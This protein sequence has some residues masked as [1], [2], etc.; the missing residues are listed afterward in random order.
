M[1]ANLTFGPTELLVNDASPQSERLW[2]VS[3]Q[4]L[5]ATPDGGFVAIW[6]GREADQSGWDLEARLLDQNGEVTGEA[7]PIAS[8]TLGDQRNAVI[9]V[10]DD[11]RLIA[12]WQSSP[13]D[14]SGW[15][16]VTRQFTATGTPLTEET[17]V[18]SST[19]GIQQHP[20]IAI[21]ENQDYV[22]VWEG[23]GA[24]DSHG[25]FFQRFDSA[26]QSL[27]QETLV[28]TFTR[29]IQKSPYVTGTPDGGFAI[30]WDGLGEGDL[31]E[32]YLQRFD[33]QG[34]RLRAEI[35]VGDGLSGI[36]RFPSVA[37]SDNGQLA[38]AWENGGADGNQHGVFARVFDSSGAA[39]TDAFG[40]NQ[41]TAG[42]Q[43]Y[44]TV[45]FFGEDELIAVWSGEGSDDRR[46]VFLRQFDVTDGTPLDAETAINI[47]EG[48]PQRFPALV[49]NSN[50]HLVAWTGQ[51]TPDNRGVYSRSFTATPPVPGVSI[52]DAS[53]AEGDEGSRLVDVTVTLDAT[54]EETITVDFATAPGT[55]LAGE[56]YETTSGQLE[57][58]PGQTQQTI[59]VSV[60][61]DTIDESDET[62]LVE[63]SNVNGAILDRAS[64]VVT[65]TDDDEA[66]AITVSSSSIE[67]GDAGESSN[68]VFEVQLSQ[69]SGRSI[70][71]DFESRPGTA[72]SAVDFSD[73]SG[74][75]TFSPGTTL[76]TVSV[77]VLGDDVDELDETFEI[78]LSGSVNASIAS[79]VETGTILDDD[80]EPLLS[81]SDVII[82]EGDTGQ[83]IAE[84]AVNLSSE[85]GQTVTVDF[86]SAENSATEGTDYQS[87]SG[88]LTF[89]PGTT[90]Q[91]ISVAILNDL[92]DE[93]DESFFLN[94]SSSVNATISDGQSLVTILDNDPVPSISISDASIAE[95]Q[96]GQ[97]I[98]SFP[99]TLS[100][101]SSRQ[102]TVAFS[103]SDQSA[104][105]G[106]DYLAANGT[107]TFE[108][109]TT[110][111]VVQVS[112]LGDT[113]E[114]PDESFLVN[115]SA[116]SNSVIEDD[117]AVGTIV[118][119]DVLPEIQIAAASI[120]EGD[121]GLTQLTFP[122]I[123]TKISGS[124]VLFDYATRDGSAL[125]ES[126]F[127]ASNGTVT[128]PAG[129]TTAQISIDVLT[130]LIEE[131]DEQ[132]FIDFSNPVNAT[133]DDTTVDGTIF[134]DDGSDIV[135]SI[136]DFSIQEPDV[137]S[138][139][140][141]LTVSAS[142]LQA[143]TITVDYVT[144][145]GTALVGDDYLPAS[146]TLT[147]T[148]EMQE[149]TIEVSVLGD[150]INE[151]IEAFSV[152]L[153][154]ASL[155]TISDATGTV[156]I[157]DNDPVPVVSI[158][159]TIVNEGESTSGETQLAPE[160]REEA[161]VG[162]ESITIGDF[163]NDQN[164]DLAVANAT[165]DT[166]TVLLNDGSG[167]YESS[168]FDVSEF[169]TSIITVDVDG[170][171]DLDLVTANRDDNSISLLLNDGN[172]VFEEDSTVT[173]NGTPASVVSLDA[174]SD[175]AADLGVA[176]QDGVDAGVLLFLN[177]GNGNFAREVLDDST[178]PFLLL[179][180]ELNGDTNPD[181]IALVD[182]SPGVLVLT[183]DSSGNTFSSST[184]SLEN[185]PVSATIFD[186][187]S[188]SDSDLALIDSTFGQIFVFSNDGDGNFG[189]PEGND[190]SVSVV[191][192][193][194]SLVAADFDGDEREDLVLIDANID[195]LLVFLNLNNGEFG[196]PSQHA[197]GEAPF[198]T[199]V[200]DLNGDG[201][202]DVA[203]ANFLSNDVSI[204]LNNRQ[205]TSAAFT[206]RLS[207]PSN[208]TVSVDYFTVNGTAEDEETT[209]DFLQ[210]IGTAVFQPGMTE[211]TV[212][213]PILDDTEPEDDELFSVRLTN[214][215][216][217]DIGDDE[218]EATIRDTDS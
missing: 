127:V 162:A 135:I 152:Q 154:N 122:V 194:R 167:E 212:F 64:S 19:F 104:T 84:V 202:N 203:T 18:N 22:I 94:L 103:T 205:R 166:V 195:R 134:D 207:S 60:L 150:L 209:G 57:F 97:S 186:A 28:N 177:D 174:N 157:V 163:N 93:D 118:S 23:R 96:S 101:A 7:F 158:S 29:G 55:A 36:N 63:L 190:V 5:A 198:S 25:I 141:A 44:P 136:S 24:D 173:I 160:V 111:Q 119:D 16:I 175:G 155:G 27:G 62:F 112:I 6:N 95:G 182:N 128:I 187:D 170:D 98:L 180:G 146:G 144:V 31:G 52:A 204:L 218:G 10:A 89:A 9:D 38:V 8:T 108:P 139:V 37:V 215:F 100:S 201:E 90:E 42:S 70:S 81:I 171:L 149:L 161:G 71:V 131:P 33:A 169:P 50:Q 184:I 20:S 61:G 183:N 30:A 32:V 113:E 69:A 73:V 26:G 2:D 132:F 39:S 99:V 199:V 206:L 85:S 210:T 72:S 75:L 21:L 213:V 45:S 105:A 76:Q 91:T 4:S 181:L 34:S 65:I 80:A 3:S 102:V 179:T 86:I 40:L 172:G 142:P 15:G 14:G 56:D 126:D 11:G 79:A 165:E 53:V 151:P 1:L 49:A 114:E 159:D 123:L 87:S 12:A 117:Q 188:D 59:Q 109:G 121:S 168:S 216:N 83:T 137:G 17:I 147:F 129:Q 35:A 156:T 92:I 43:Q 47:T 116:P 145:D 176:V 13:Q 106:D 138:V 41:T 217:A 197:V 48:G 120:V 133:L 115:L 54:S 110:S 67:E 189:D 88:T 164:A 214:A 46:G 68:L 178:E 191:P 196:I 153:S 82:S 148:P 200:G 211:V 74:T 193:A 51:G 77:P 124:D 143:E 107:L 192:D 140:V 78:V 208:Q 66:P 58:L 130:D 125:S 185:R